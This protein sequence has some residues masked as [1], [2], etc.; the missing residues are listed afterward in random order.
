MEFDKEEYKNQFEEF[1]RDK[2]IKKSFQ[3]FKIKLFLEK[4]ENSL[5]IAKHT[6]DIEPT[7]DQPKKLFWDYWAITISYYSMLYATKAAIL[8]K[9]Y[10]VSDHDAAQIALGHLLIPD[11]IEK[12]D[13]EILNQAYKIFKDEYVHY[14]EDAKKESKIARYSAIK[15]YTKRR[16]DEIFNNATDFV[17]KIGFVLQDES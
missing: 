1:I 12:E 2:R 15:T 16:L 13:L 8:S 9:G 14:F 4:A 17:A 7:E 11:E 3:S 6:K 10:E 5:L